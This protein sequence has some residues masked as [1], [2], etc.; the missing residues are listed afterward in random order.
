MTLDGGLFDESVGFDE[1]FQDRATSFH[2][3]SSVKLII[4]E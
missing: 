2:G 4:I 1:N 3:I